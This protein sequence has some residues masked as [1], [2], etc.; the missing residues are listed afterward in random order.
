MREGGSKKGM[1]VIGYIR[2]ST[3]DQATNGQSLEAQESKIRAWALLNDIP[4]EDVLIFVDAGI[5]GKSMRKRKG[6]ADALECIGSGDALVFYSL[7]RLARSTKD[8][9]EIADSLR[10]KGA[11]LVSISEKLDTTTAAGRM[12]FTVLAAMSQFERD[13]ASERVTMV[14]Q[15]KKANGERTGSVPYGYRLGDD[16]IHLVEDEGEQ[17]VI[18]KVERLRAARNSYRKISDVLY[19]GGFVSRNGRP[20]EAMQIKRM[21]SD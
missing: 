8:A 9:L 4:A 1:R 13:L 10:D 19:K 17:L 6:L 12:I 16:G 7:S 18:R 21:L 5:S 3:E 11:D 2:V 14:L 15:H 20:F